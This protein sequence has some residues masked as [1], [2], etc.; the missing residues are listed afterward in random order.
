M[1]TENTLILRNDRFAELEKSEL[2]KP[3]LIFKKRKMLMIFISIKFNDEIINLIEII[4]KNSYNLS[5]IQF[6]QFDQI[7]LINLLISTDLINSRN[8]I[9]KM[10][11]SKDQYVTQK[12]KRTYIAI[13][14]SSEVNF[15]LFLTA[16]II[17]SK[18]K[19]SKR[20]NKV[21]ATRTPYFYT[22]TP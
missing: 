12:A 9:R 4:S 16:Q 19:D 21:I 2:K 10:I 14:T 7:Q 5:F 22:R 15:N 17:N 20:L 8:Q 13:M 6:K 3:K 18:E 11:T 1:Q